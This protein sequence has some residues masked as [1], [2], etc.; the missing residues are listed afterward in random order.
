MDLQDDEDDIIGACEEKYERFFEFTIQ[1]VQNQMALI[2][3]EL[4][5]LHVEH[6]NLMRLRCSLLDEMAKEKAKTRQRK[7]KE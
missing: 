7:T 4:H 5:H 6:R 2:R 3:A 1:S